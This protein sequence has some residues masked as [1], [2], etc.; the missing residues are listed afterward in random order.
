MN[1]DNAWNLLNEAI[2]SYS[3]RGI[4]HE[5]QNFTGKLNLKVALSNKVLQLISFA[6]GDTGETY[7]EEASWIGKD[8]AGVLTLYVSSNNHPGVTPHTFN[9]IDTGSNGEQ[10][11]IFRFGNPEDRNSFREE[12]TIALYQD[13]SIRHQYSWGMPGG[14]FA[15]RSGSRMSKFS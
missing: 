5:G 7:H 3:G 4:N 2:G 14:D 15:D 1:Q 6:T 11:I 13:G 12:V 10:K 8:I 9:R